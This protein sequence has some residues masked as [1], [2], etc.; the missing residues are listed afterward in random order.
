MGQLLLDW[1]PLSFVVRCQETK[2]DGRNAKLF[3][4]ETSVPLLPNQKHNLLNPSDAFSKFIPLWPL[5]CRTDRPDLSFILSQFAIYLSHNPIPQEYSFRQN[6]ELL[7]YPWSDS[8]GV[9]LQSQL[10]TPV[11]PTDSAGVFPQ[12]QPNTCITHR[13]RNPP[14]TRHTHDPIPQGYSFRHNPFNWA[15]K[16]SKAVSPLTRES[17]TLLA[18]APAC[19]PAAVTT[20][21]FILDE[22]P[23]LPSE[24]YIWSTTTTCFFFTLG[25]KI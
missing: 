24:I 18:A 16:A 21:D 19:A 25:F 22:F 12:K 13:F 14:N 23:L 17:T 10:P 8:V 1:R 3:W 15:S 7:S 9:F 6:L 5:S 2:R 11:L 20:G 4:S